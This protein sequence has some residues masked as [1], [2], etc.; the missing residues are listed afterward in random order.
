MKKNG[1]NGAEYVRKKDRERFFDDNRNVSF[2]GNLLLRNGGHD[3]PS[4][5][6]SIKPFD[7]TPY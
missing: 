7:C 3:P 6:C 2:I 4:D 5:L 1:M